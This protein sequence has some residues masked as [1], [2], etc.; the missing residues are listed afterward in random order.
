MIENGDDGR[1]RRGIRGMVRIGKVEKRE[2]LGRRRSERRKRRRKWV[3]P[4]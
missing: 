3:G 2:R 4:G 1:R